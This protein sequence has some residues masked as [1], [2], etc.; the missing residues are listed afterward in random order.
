MAWQREPSL[1]ISLHTSYLFMAYALHFCHLEML[2]SRAILKGFHLSKQIERCLAGWEVE[3]DWLCLSLYSHGPGA[4][5][6]APHLHTDA[7]DPKTKVMGES[8][9][10]LRRDIFFSIATDLFMFVFNAILRAEQQG[11]CPCPK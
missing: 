6:C 5:R 7:S 11:P 2:L 3:M 10:C 4:A 8:C 1:Q 9:P